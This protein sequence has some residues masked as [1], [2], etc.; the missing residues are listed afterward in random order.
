MT[1]NSALTVGK[2]HKVL[3]NP[4]LIKWYGQNMIPHF[5]THGIPLGLQNKA[6]D[7]W[8]Y[9]ICVKNLHN[10]KDNMLYINFSLKTNPRR[11]EIFNLLNS[12][13]FVDS[14]KCKWEEYIRQ[15]S[16]HKFCISPP[17]AGVDCHRIWEAIYV[18]CIPIVEKDDIL[19]HHFHDLPIL[20]I[21][22]YDIIDEIFLKKEYLKFKDT[23]N[24]SLNKTKL[25]Y[26]YEK[27]KPN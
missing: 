1:H 24:F 2:H 9:N 13:G 4:Y 23:S 6:W 26:W 21:D 18:G 16:T 10:V 22:N 7:G 14:P 3:N 12:K 27:F 15:L 25:S 20:F 8:N 11:Q 5:K 19:Y 17:G